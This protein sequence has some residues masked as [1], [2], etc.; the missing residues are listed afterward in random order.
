MGIGMADTANTVYRDFVTDGVPSSGKNKPK[1]SEIRR[2]LTGYETIINAFLSNGGLIYSSKAALDADLARGANSMAWVVGDA[3][4]GNNGVYMKF[5]AAGTGSWVRVADLPFSFI[6]AS[7]VGAGTPNAIQATTSIPVSGSALVWCNVFETNT[8]SPVTISF[9]GGAALTIKTNS[10]NEP[11][12]GGLPAGMIVMGIASGSTFRL[13]SDQASSAIVAAAEAAQAAAEAAAA[14]V[15]LPAPVARTYLRQKSDVSGYETMNQSQVAAD[16]LGASSSAGIGNGVA[17]NAAIFSAAV[18]TL[19]LVPGTYVVSSNTTINA[20]VMAF[21]GAIFKP[22]ANVTIT[23]ANEIQ[24]YPYRLFDLSA[25]NSSIAGLRRAQME[26]FVEH[27]RGS[28]SSPPATNARPLIQ[29]AVNSVIDDG[30]LYAG[31]GRWLLDGTVITFTGQSFCG[32]G[33]NDTWFMWSGATTNGFQRLDAGNGLRGGA[34]RGFRM[35]PATPGTIPT[36]GVALLCKQSDFDVHDYHIEDCFDGM[37]FDTVVSCNT[38]NFE[39]KGARNSG[40]KTKN[41]NDVFCSY[42]LIEAAGDW[43]TVNV[44]SGTAFTLFETVSTTSGTGSNGTVIAKYS[45]TSYRISFIGQQPLATSV[46][47]G[48]TSGAVGTITAITVGHQEG[49]I[50]W[51]NKNESVTLAEIDVI[52]GRFGITSLGTNAPGRTGNPAWNRILSSVYFDT[53]YEGSVL[54]GVTGCTIDAWFSSSRNQDAYGLALVNARKIKGSPHVANNSGAGVQW[55]NTCRDIE[56]HNIDCDGNC[57]NASGG[58]TTMGEI[59]VLGAATRWS[60]I[61]GVA[62]FQGENGVTPVRALYIAPAAGDNIRVIGLRV[63]AGAVA[64]G[65][66]G[67]DQTWW[68]VNGVPQRLPLASIPAFASDAAAR[69]GGIPIGGF[70]RN[71]SAVQIRVT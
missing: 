31:A 18:G 29:A 7:D 49:G 30:T 34:W 63:P 42:G 45:N 65:A 1:K 71:G 11:A 55:D 47:T 25:S 16:I 15:N 44:T 23:F 48:Q 26:W 51:S 20:R 46:L 57:V 6:I 10:G 9:N 24:A 3:T 28:A 68:G 27:L 69:T 41:L 60:L 54:N 5:G 52:G 2:L 19:I 56:F 33:R 32:A 35:V 58:G 17:D 50:R 38:F 59:R 14:S 37:F 39:I 66:T 64:N 53:A 36:A 13:V 70:Y 40:L 67:S 62:G 21:P 61:G 43:V 4:V 22:G 8:G 12:P